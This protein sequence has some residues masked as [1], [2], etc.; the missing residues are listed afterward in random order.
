VLGDLWVAIA[1][2]WWLRW[3]RRVW[4]RKS[5]ARV[6]AGLRILGRLGDP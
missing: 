4:L 1:P 3:R 2:M 6:A 5:N